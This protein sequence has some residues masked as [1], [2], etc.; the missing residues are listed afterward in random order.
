MVRRSASHAATRERVPGKAEALCE[1]QRQDR[2]RLSQPVEHIGDAG[3]A[4]AET[5]AYR[6]PT[7]L[8]EPSGKIK[9]G[10]VGLRFDDP[11][12]KSSTELW[13]SMP[14]SP[15]LWRSS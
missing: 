15:M 2:D 8:G 6:A 11:T 10:L 7:A 3:G 12:A 13:S 1:E 5:C 14:A 9:N 4:G